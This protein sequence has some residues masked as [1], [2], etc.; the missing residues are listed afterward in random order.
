VVVRYATT[1]TSKQYVTQQ[2]W[3][4]A[5]LERCPL[6]PEGGCGLGGHGSYPRVR[7]A[8][9]RVARLRCPKAGVTISLLPDFLAARLSGTL[10]EVEQAVEAAERAKSLEGAAG[11]ARPA[12]VSDA[13]TLPSALRW[14]RRRLSPVR[15]A[16]LALVTLLP[17][18]FGCAP[19]IAGLRERLG[20]SSVLIALR[21]RAEQQLGA[22]EAPLGFRARAAQATSTRSGSPH[23]AGPDPPSATR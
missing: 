14:L 6:H 13:V 21:A 18:L 22:L 23:E 16:L 19:T 5:T 10:A 2:A 3:R 15:T 12:D 9:I 1:L 17:E 4:T 11:R 20:V 7:P 8:G